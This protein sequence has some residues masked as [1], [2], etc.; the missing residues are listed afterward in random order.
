MYYFYLVILPGVLLSLA[1]FGTLWMSFEVGE[2]LGY[3]ITL[4]LALQVMQ[5]IVSAAIPIAGVSHK[6]G[7]HVGSV[8][9]ISAT[10][11]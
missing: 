9:P 8:K 3:N 6:R 10:N 2:R 5:G 11:T 4:V 1:S 7:P